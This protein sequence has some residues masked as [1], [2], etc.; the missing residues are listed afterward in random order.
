MYS[1]VVRVSRKATGYP[2]RLIAA[3]ERWKKS[4]S[5][6]VLEVERTAVIPEVDFN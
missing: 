3:E 1:S 5:P 6:P 2:G 4:N